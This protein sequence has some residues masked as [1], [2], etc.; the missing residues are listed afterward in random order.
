[1]KRRK[2]KEFSFPILLLMGAGFALGTVSA[3]ALLLAVVSYFTADPTALTGAFS[4]LALVLAGAVSGFATSRVRGEGG[5]LVAVVSAVIS[6]AF[7]LAV[8]LVWR[9]GLLPL[10]AILNL[11][12]F[13][14][15]SVLCA[16]IGKRRKRKSCAWRK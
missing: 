9:R 8:G 14:I 16:L 7:M 10:G 12:V 5:V 3:T 4:L 2:R 6:T 13:I 15:V 11:A 1:M